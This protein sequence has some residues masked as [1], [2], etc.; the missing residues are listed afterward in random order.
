MKL[1]FVPQFILNTS[2]RKFAFNYFKNIIKVNKKF[3]G[4]NWDKKMK[5]NPDF[6]MFFKKK[7]EEYIPD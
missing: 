4:S 5:E 2:A 1:N 7:I 6:Y 3:E